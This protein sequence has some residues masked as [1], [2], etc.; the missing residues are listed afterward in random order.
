L[1]D[2][3][4]TKLLLNIFPSLE[5]GTC[6]TALRTFNKKA[7]DLKDT[8]VLCISRDL[9]YAQ[10]RFCAAEGLK[11]VITLSD[12]DSK[13]FGKKFHLELLDGLMQGLLSRVVII[14]DEKGRVTYRQQVA[15]IAD[16]PDYQA[17]L[18]ALQKMK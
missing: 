12:F 3:F 7:A 16:E 14:L 10:A 5:T 6:S 11:N 17:A 4:G 13:E 1:K 9:P 8:K 18:D 2:F 15:E